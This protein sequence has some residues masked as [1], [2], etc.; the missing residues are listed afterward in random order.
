MKQAMISCK[1]AIEIISNII[2]NSSINNEFKQLFNC[3]ELD[4][5][6]NPVKIDDQELQCFYYMMRTILLNK[7]VTTMYNKIKI[8]TCWLLKRFII[9]D[10][11]IKFME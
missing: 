1:R 6:G 3:N 7:D 10:K 4:K 9:N 8:N 2:R 11:K 5:K